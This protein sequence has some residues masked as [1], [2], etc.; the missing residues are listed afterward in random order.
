MMTWLSHVEGLKVVLLLGLMKLL[1]AADDDVCVCVCVCVCVSLSLSISIH[2]CLFSLSHGG[3]AVPC[4]HHPRHVK[5]QN[6]PDL[7][8]AR[9]NLWYWYI[10]SVAT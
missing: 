2:L 10:S 6:K 9:N 3:L 7:K 5:K 4:R 1:R 8:H